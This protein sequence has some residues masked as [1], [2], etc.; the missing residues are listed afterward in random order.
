MAVSMK[1]GGLYGSVRAGINFMRDAA[2]DPALFVMYRLGQSHI[3]PT[4]D[5]IGVTLRS[6][7]G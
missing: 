2:D 5:A 3:G 7:Y 4:A 1:K 6:E